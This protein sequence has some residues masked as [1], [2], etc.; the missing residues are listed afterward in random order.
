[1]KKS[2]HFLFLVVI[3]VT[4]A[5][6]IFVSA[7][8]SNCYTLSGYYP[9][10]LTMI[11]KV[12]DSLSS[13]VAGYATSAS[14]TWNYAYSGSPFRFYKSGSSTGVIAQ[15]DGRSDV[16][17]VNFTD[18]NLPYNTVGVCLK[19]ATGSTFNEFDIMLNTIVAWGN[20]HNNNYNDYIGEFTH[21]FGHA[22]GLGDY[23]GAE[24]STTWSGDA[25][26][27]TM[28]YGNRANPNRNNLTYYFRDLSNGDIQGL[29]KSLER[30]N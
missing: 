16:G 9:S 5:L 28:W 10:S 19:S 17:M 22:T 23:R 24:S 1:M 14:A 12:H 11:W 13:T 27:P 26:V 20:G 8:S 30:V 6:S 3:L 21:E 18:Y 29:R 25:D 2:K 15:F 7:N 4:L